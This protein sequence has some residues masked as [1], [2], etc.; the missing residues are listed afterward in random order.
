MCKL[1][2]YA[3]HTQHQMTNALSISRNLHCAA[4]VH[5]WHLYL[6]HATRTVCST[7]VLLNLFIPT[8]TSE[9]MCLSGTT[10]MFKYRGQTPLK[11]TRGELRYHQWY[12]LF[13]VYSFF[14][15]AFGYLLWQCQHMFSHAKKAHLHSHF[16]RTKASE[17]LF[18]ITHTY[19][20]AHILERVR[21]SLIN[22]LN[23]HYQNNCSLNLCHFKGMIP[24]TTLQYIHTA[25][26]AKDLQNITD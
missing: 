19:L 4:T 17:P 24:M 20:G 22:Q 9:T 18:Y 26:Q 13:I 21:S 23:D 3:S 2:I 1:L 12:T 14:C 7:S 16:T 15:I 25:R 11:T 6:C 10:I 5:P 8:T